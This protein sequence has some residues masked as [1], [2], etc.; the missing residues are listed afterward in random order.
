[1]IGVCTVGVCFNNFVSPTPT[2]GQACATHADCYVDIDRDA[3]GIL[4][5]LDNCVLTANGPLAGP[6]NQVDTDADGLG[7]ACDGD[8]AGTVVVGRC[9]ANGA[10][11]P[12]PGT[13]QPVAC[14]NALGLGDFCQRSLANS[15][16]CSAN[17]DDLD[18]DGV[19]DAV[20]NCPTVAN[21][22]VYA[23]GPQRDRDRDGLGDSC[24]PAAAHDDLPDGLPDDVVTFSGTLACHTRPLAR[25]TLIDYPVYLDVDGDHDQFPDTGERGRF[26][27]VVR[28]DGPTLENAVLT[29]VS[30]DPDVAC[31]SESQIVVPSLPAGATMTLG[32]L[33]PGQPGFGFVASDALQSQ[34]LPAPSR[35]DL[36]IQVAGP[37]LLGLAAPL[38][39]SLLAD[40]DMPPGTPQVYV[41]GP[42]GMPGT[43]DDGKAV[44]NFDV[45]RNGDGSITVRDTFLQAIAPGV[46]RGSCSNAPLTVCATAADCPASPPGAVCYSGAYVRASATGSELNRVAA[47]SCG[48]FETATNYP[49]CALDPDFPMD[50]HLH[51]PPGATSCPNVESGTCVGGCSFGTPTGGQ[52][53]LSGGNSLHMGAH[54]VPGDNLA[55]DTTH[56]RALQ[57]FM[58]APLNLA[59]LPRPGDLDLSFFHIARLMDNNGV[60]PNNENQCA[61]CADVQIQV[62]QDPD[63]AVDAWG[64]WDKLAPYQNVYDHKPNAWSVFGGYYCVFTP[65]DTGTAPPNPRGVHETICYPQGA[66]SSCGSTIGLTS[67]STGDCAGPGSVDPSGVG[68]WVQTRFHL[69][70]YLGRRVR[71]RWIA[72][73]WAFDEHSSSYYQ[74][75]GTWAA[76]QQ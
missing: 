29:L 15:G 60:G 25:L 59:L 31:I 4:D 17:G 74:I 8:C 68:V 44:E 55:G 58:S 56:L 49:A 10:I 69:D 32:S 76:T 40:Y 54:F 14:A 30:S 62:D 5:A 11:C 57:G 52:R 41:T 33:D 23:G 43:A 24:D 73:S 71:V 27:I 2:I 47:V 38:D 66:W 53:A 1:Q 48:G 6:S 13:S 37:G 36:Q 7:D 67:A 26:T 18:A 35:I 75:G 42:D 61:D 20:D 45:D 39:V 21:P 46:F 34:P 28:N 65:T 9:R 51:C 16:G 22:P 3:D 70:G 12:N 64:F 50:W 19:L 63:P 72:E